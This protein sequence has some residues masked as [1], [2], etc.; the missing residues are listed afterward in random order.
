MSKG[1]RDGTPPRPQATLRGQTAS[2]KGGSSAMTASA[3]GLERLTVRLHFLV[4]GGRLLIES[5]NISIFRRERQNDL[6]R[7]LR[8]F[9]RLL[10]F[11]SKQLSTSRMVQRP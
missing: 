8:L 11:G 5:K 3:Q 6:A 7:E 9:C 2:N 1:D 10:F 4:S